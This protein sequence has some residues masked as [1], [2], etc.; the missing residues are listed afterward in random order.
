M[1]GGSTPHDPQVGL[2]KLVEQARRAETESDLVQARATYEKALRRLTRDDPPVAKSSLLRWIGRTHQAEGDFDAAL[3]CFHAALAVARVDHAP[4]EVAQALNCWGVLLFQ[5]GQTSEAEQLY[6]RAR[7]EALAVGD[8]HVL[9]L[10][11]QNLGNVAGVHGDLTVALRHYRRSLAGY[12][13]LDLLEHVGPLLNNMGRTLTD[14]GAWHDA[15]LILVRALHACARVGD[16][17]HYVL[18]TV[19]Q[20]RLHLA[21][22]E[23]SQ[24]RRRCDD[25]S[26]LSSE[27]P[28]D[29]WRGEIHRHLGEVFLRTGRP[30][31][32][33]ASFRMALAEAVQRHDLL[34][35]AEVAKAMARLFRS[36]GRNREVLE[37]LTRAHRAF[38]AVR[39]R[40]DLADV[41]RQLEQLESSFV[42]VVREWGDAIESKD[43]YT[44]G[45]C[46]RVADYACT[47]AR[48]S[49][50]E[51]RS[52][53]WFRMG[54]LLH[55]V[56]KINV[57]SHI[58]NK[59]GPLTPEEWSVMRGHPRSGVEL[60][61]SVD[62]P[63]DIRPMVLHH[64]E[65]WDGAGYP[66]GLAGEGIPLPARILCVADVFDALTTARSYRP[67]LAP[68][69]AFKI[70]ERDAG[71]VFDPILIR[72]FEPIAHSAAGR[73]ATVG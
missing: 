61:Q 41:A 48:A 7:A 17:S 13:R 66:D 25:A 54:A 19:N 60:L 52:L 14:L 50:L 3:D 12:E 47:L 16:R 4:S 59:P 57:P 33:E 18:V 8:A 31:L 26:R 28:D 73:T 42:S 1:P 64:H 24:A 29:A 72:R 36:G 22:G 27:L 44:Q 21:R 34:L 9:A 58:L 51:S 23:L 62:F 45:H 10:I 6:R 65:R 53:T 30:S 35:E 15:E 49:G 11:E 32:A 40:R 43:R 63:W 69:A 56:G 71:K 68:D 2:V 70:I 55:D 5:S 20:A 39:A 37:F 46:Q 38:T 67:A